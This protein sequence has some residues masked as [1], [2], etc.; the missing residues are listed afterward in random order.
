LGKFYPPHHGGIETLLRSLCR[1]L[2]TRGVEV[3]CIVANDTPRT[4]HENDRGARIHRMASFGQLFST[5]LCPAYLNAARRHPADIWHAHFPNPLVDLVCLTGRRDVPL[6]LSYHSDVVRQNKM[7]W[8]YRLSL[9]RLLDRADRIV[10]ATPKHLE[11]SAWLSAFQEKCEVI[12][13]GINHERFAATADCLRQAE[14]LRAQAGGLPILLNVGRLV[15]Y[16]GQRHLVEAACQ[17]KAMVWIV[18]TGPLRH[19]LEGLAMKLGVAE[20]VR[21]WDSVD[22]RQLPVFLHASE[23]FVFPSITPN[24]AFGIAQVEAMACGKPVVSCALASGV[25]FVNLDGITGLV[26]PP[27][28]TPALA[29]AI[30]RLLDDASLRRCLGEAGRRRALDEFSEPVMVERYWRL[31]EKVRSSS[32]RS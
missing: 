10:V 3:D 11:H 30:Q 27:S 17:L 19:E 18:G 5:S 25:P 8:V 13:Y 26:V 9:L 29:R 20:R 24:E 12:P 28:D 32:R 15:G 16:K 31:F 14:E 21:F 2:A 6:V 4:V 22:E 23:V 7:M 1:G